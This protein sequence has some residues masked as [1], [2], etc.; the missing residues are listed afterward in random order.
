MKSKTVAIAGV[1]VVAVVA[2]L[3]G[4]AALFVM[5]HGP[6]FE[7]VKHLLE[8]RIATL[9]DQ[10]VLVVE[11]KGDPA[12]VAGEA[13][14][15]L[16]K[17][18]F[19]LKGVPKGPKQPAPRARWPLSLN[20]PKEQWIG[21]YA[22]PVP[23]SVSSL[24]EQTATAS[25]LHAELATWE[26]GQVAEILHVGSYS[27]EEPTIRKLLQFVKDSGHQPIGE[28]EEEYLKGPGMFSMGDPKKY[29]T[30]IRYRLKKAERPEG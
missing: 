10:R 24:P 3:I 22:M 11:A 27:E 29:L 13:F 14:G 15:L 18:Y 28:H 26:Y 1:I 5:P 25:G 2:V 16:F 20:T 7:D 6:K 8:P 9:P 4:V 21:R 17:T 30:I 12:A 23:D 19:K